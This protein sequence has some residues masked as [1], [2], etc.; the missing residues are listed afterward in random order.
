M[1]L[2][3]LFEQTLV[4][5]DAAPSRFSAALRA[6]NLGSLEN[7]IED[8]RSARIAGD[9]Q[10][11]ALHAISL[12][13]ALSR[14]DRMTRGHTER[15]RAYA[16]L[17]AEEMGLSQADRYQLAWGVLL[18]DI[19]KL[20]V[21]PEI[22]TKK[23]KLTD[24]EWR[25]LRTHPEAGAELV[26]P[27]RAWLGDWVN[28]TSDH[29]ERWD[30]QGYPNQLAGTEIS[31]SGRITAVA[32]AFDVIS[33]TRS[34]KSAMSTEAARQELVRCAGT[35]FDPTVVRAMVKVSIP[36]R[37][38]L[39]ALAWLA[40]VPTVL[41]PLLAAASTPAIAA[42]TAAATVTAG[43]APINP[44]FDQAPIEIAFA[45]DDDAPTTNESEA[46][47]STAPE[48]ETVDL[49]DLL[50][51]ST[52]TLAV[53]L[54]PTTSRAPS[55]TAT[56]TTDAPAGLGNI[57]AATEG[58][59][60]DDAIDEGAVVTTIGTPEQTTTST[61]TTTTT[62]ST[63][64]TTEA[65]AISELNLSLLNSA[66][67]NTTSSA[68]LPLTD[69]TVPAGRLGNFD[70]DRDNEPG[71]LVQMGAAGLATTDPDLVQSWSFQFNE[72][73][74]LDN[75]SKFNIFVASPGF[76]SSVQLGLEVEVQHCAAA[77]TQLASGSTMVNSNGNWT[78]ASIGLGQL[79]ADIA[80]GDRLVL[81]LVVPDQ[82]SSSDVMLAYGVRL[83][84]SVLRLS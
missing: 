18:H 60:G 9:N 73:T 82:L 65:I 59:T 71:L 52:T 30:G 11:A 45:D 74:R 6:S 1:P 7:R 49:A 67:G 5:P 84:S 34:Y 20:A 66:P 13:A 35:Q 54:V 40:E 14:H 79:T 33:S 26:E 15:V 50:S 69:G 19:G 39:G 57:T 25:T 44:T 70:T 58:G 3:H 41:R 72:A 36:T 32:D 29:H 24:D 53:V 8:I 31:L 56:P 22:L 76:E 63:S 17:I 46:P 23:G 4:F 28:A 42:S 83:R 55:T 21:P 43:V 77:C 48:K 75:D 80:A 62:P 38:N 16:D 64:I 10:A 47:A 78:R 81:R 2:A 27:L 12:I 51:A 37:R 68:V 61:S